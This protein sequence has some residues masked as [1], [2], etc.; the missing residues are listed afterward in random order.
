MSSVHSRASRSSRASRASR[1]SRASARSR[2]SD[3]VRQL[4]FSL[5]DAPPSPGGGKGVEDA[6]DLASA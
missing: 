4:D 2:L 3:R 5:A 1:S 6:I